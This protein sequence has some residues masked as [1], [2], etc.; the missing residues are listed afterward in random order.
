MENMKR[1][2]GNNFVKLTTSVTVDDSAFNHIPILDGINVALAP[3]ESKPSVQPPVASLPS[4]VKSVCN[5]KN[6]E[7]IVDPFSQMVIKIPSCPPGLLNT[8][9]EES[10]KKKKQTM[11]AVPNVLDL[12]SL[13]S[14][15]LQPAPRKRKRHAMKRTRNDAA[16]LTNSDDKMM[17]S[18]HTTATIGQAD[19]IIFGKQDL[20][21]GNVSLH[22][23]LNGKILY[24]TEVHV[25]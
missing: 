24:S 3:S 22:Q 19:T 17:A 23:S 9:S 8:V 20:L 15:L 25:M 16:S 12:N 4:A 10:I 5:Y 2:A 6:I 7:T 21:E 18:V 13:N 11:S 1:I 14:V